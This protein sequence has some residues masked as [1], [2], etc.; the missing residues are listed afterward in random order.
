[1]LKGHNLI[2]N[3]ESAEGKISLQVFST[4]QQMN[5]P[6]KFAAATDAEVEQAVAKA[7]NAFEIYKNISPENKALFLEN[8]AVEIEN[9]GDEL[10]E[11]AKLETGLTEQRLIGERG[12][13]TGQLKLFAAL[14][15]EGSWVEAVIDKAIPERKPL[16]RSDLRKMNVPIGPVVVFGASN[17]PFAFS[18]AGGDTASAL[19][20]GNPVIVKAH[21]SHLGTNEL[22]AS[23]IKKAVAKTNMPDGVFS[24]VIG[25]GML[26][27]M[28]LVKNPGVKAVGFTG[29]YRGGMAI[30]KA[31]VNERESPIPVY[32]EMSSVNPVLV[33]PS[34]LKKDLPSAV[35]MLSG[36][37]TLGVGQFCTNPGLIFIIEDEFFE[38]FIKQLTASLAAIPAGVMLNAGICKSYYI[39]RQA[40]ASKTAVKVLHLGDNYSESFKG[41]ATLFEIDAEHFI[42][43]PDLQ[44]EIFGPSSLI[45]K[46]RDKSILFRAVQSL[47]GQ[48]TGT[49]LGDENDLKQFSDSVNAIHEKVGRLIFNGVPTGVEVNHAMVHGGPF[50]ATTDPRTTSVGADAIKRFVRPFCYQDF[51]S[52]YLPDALK[53]EN[54]LHIIRKING[55]YTRDPI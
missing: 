15:R 13:T 39:N 34:K 21:E 51:P 43:N 40:V 14:L 6:E 35:N 20:A 16:P 37:I 30:F 23:A 26:T 48:L 41:S 10:V 25:D 33:L 46:C 52:E 38:E 24:F 49:I 45:V 4:I 12:R 7:I 31:A 28:Q 53:N 50:P 11:R 27:G 44:N 36:S 54:P 1:M 3:T 17:F 5:L 42:S 9:I 55:M 47:H 18:T 22:I 8:I 32:A 2:G 29:S 19:A